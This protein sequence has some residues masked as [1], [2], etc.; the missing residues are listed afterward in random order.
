MSKKL[1][2]AQMR[3]FYGL[4]ENTVDVIAFGRSVE[5][6]MKRHGSKR[7]ELTYDEIMKFT[8]R[9]TIKSTEPDVIEIL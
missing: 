8:P 9:A 7:R 3:K 4:P 2:K 5:N 1:T 6:K